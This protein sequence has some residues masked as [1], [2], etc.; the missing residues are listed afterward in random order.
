MSLLK[1]LLI[2]LRVLLYPPLTPLYYFSIII[3]H[4]NNLYKKKTCSTSIFLFLKIT[5][6][7]IYLKSKTKY[8]YIN[9]KKFPTKKLSI[10]KLKKIKPNQPIIP[11]T[12]NP[13]L[14]KIL[15]KIIFFL[16]SS[17]C[18][19][20]IQLKTNKQTNKQKDNCIGI[21]LLDIAIDLI[22]NSTTVFMHY[23]I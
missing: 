19:H 13:V 9:P 12:N 8:I 23:G 11:K 2:L 10:V 4:I 7:F 16:P 5:K 20:Q 17:W 15:S 21:H 1:I 18:T 6:K 3:Y 14:Y 22:S